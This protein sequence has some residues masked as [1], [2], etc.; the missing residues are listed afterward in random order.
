MSP[1][2]LWWEA[3][4]ILVVCRSTLGKP[5]SIPSLR[6]IEFAQ[7]P[8]RGSAASPVVSQEPKKKFYLFTLNSDLARISLFM[9]A[10]RWLDRESDIFFCGCAPGSP[11][12]VLLAALTPVE[13]IKLYAETSWAASKNIQRLTDSLWAWTGRSKPLTPLHNSRAYVVLLTV[14]WQGRAH[15]CASSSGIKGILS[16]QGINCYWA[17]WVRAIRRICR[18]FRL[19]VGSRELWETLAMMVA[20]WGTMQLPPFDNNKV[21]NPITAPREQFWKIT[22]SFHSDTQNLT[23]TVLWFRSPLLNSVTVQISEPPAVWHHINRYPREESHQDEQEK[24]C[25]LCHCIRTCTVSPLII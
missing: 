22:V 25:P 10:S 9:W 20:T 3:W 12:M 15:Q 5:R 19:V 1:A 7:E 21:I 14:S 6:K 18:A 23:F 16:M 24:W 11:I 17:S 13:S 2:P 8:S 4:C